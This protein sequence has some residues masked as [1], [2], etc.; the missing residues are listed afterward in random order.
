[1]PSPIFLKL[2][3]SLI[4]DKTRTETVRFEVID[5]LAQE[6]L[7][8]LNLDPNLQLLLGHGSGSF[9]HVAAAKYNTRGGVHSKQ[10]W[11]G[12]AEVSSA[13]AR[14]NAIL[15]RSLTNAGVP[16]ITFQPSASALCAD[17]AIQSLRAEP[18]ERALSGGLVPVLYG[19][20]A[21]DKSLGGTI[22]STEEILSYL[23]PRLQPSALLL[24]GETEGVFDE[25]GS[26][27]RVLDKQQF[28]LDSE[29]FGA[30][31]GTDVTGGMSSKILK[32]M[33]L[34]AS[35]PQ[36]TIRIFS[37]IKPGNLEKCLLDP[38]VG[39]GTLITNS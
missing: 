21:I 28:E 26:V 22:I 24:A 9:G 29:M 32:M 6:I 7:Q 34:S 19:D 37:G 16:A 33:E 27:I 36:L 23:A 4:T 2:G 17:G 3:G 18:I 14:L 25:S 31:R 12:F 20:V 38:S 5:R 1:M 8:A 35:L 10:E 11:K 30:S 13:A 39:T 15:M